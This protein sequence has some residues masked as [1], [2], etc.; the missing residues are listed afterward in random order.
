MFVVFLNVTILTKYIY[1]Y[2]VVVNT[3]FYLKGGYNNS[4]THKTPSIDSCTVQIAN[5]V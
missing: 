1:I 2:N 3:F 4:Y 5:S